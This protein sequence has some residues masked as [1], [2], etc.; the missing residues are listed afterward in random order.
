MVGGHK[1]T[2]DG[3]SSDVEEQ[4]T[5]VDTLNR[6]GQVSSRVLCLTSCDLHYT[7]YDGE[8]GEESES[9]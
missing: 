4:D 5:D 7:K 8:H 3:G 6:L 2:D 9:D 1:K